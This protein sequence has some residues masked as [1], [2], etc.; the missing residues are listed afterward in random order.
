MSSTHNQSIREKEPREANA[1]ALQIKTLVGIA[2]RTYCIALLL[3]RNHD[4]H[5]PCWYNKDS[6]VCV[7]LFFDF[8][9]LG[10]ERTMNALLLRI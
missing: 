7:A 1:I 2:T 8:A 5:I 6:T 9:A 4:M 3:S 10:P